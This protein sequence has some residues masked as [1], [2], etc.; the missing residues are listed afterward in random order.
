MTPDPIPHGSFCYRIVDLA[1]NEVLS[2]DI[3]RFGRDLREYSYRPGRKEVLCPYWYRTDYGMVRCQF[4]GVETLDEEDSAARDLAIAHFGSEA[5]FFA[6][7]DDRILADETK[8]CGIHT[9]D[10]E[11]LNQSLINE[12]K[13]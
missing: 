11:Y 1:P 3:H 4:L 8:I 10:E 2:T 5:A 7:D 6:S 9:D 12:G 13:I